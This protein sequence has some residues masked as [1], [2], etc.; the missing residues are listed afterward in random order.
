VFTNGVDPVCKWDPTV[1]STVSIDEMDT[2]FTTP[3]TNAIDTALMVI[4]F[5]GR[6]VY[7]NT[8]ESATRFPR[9]A[10]FTAAGSFQS[11][12][13]DLDF[14]DAPAEMGDMVTGQF[15]GERFF[16][17]FET[18]WMEL[19]S[20]NDSNQP[21]VWRPF[22]SRFGAVSKLSTIQDNERLIS[23]SKTSMQALDPNGQ[24]YFDEEVPDLV[25]NYSTSNTD[26]CAAIRNES[27]RALWWTYVDVAD[28]RPNNILAATYNEKGE[29]AWS[30]YD[31]RFNVFSEFDSDQSPSWNSLG[32][33]PMNSYVGVSFNDARVGA[34][35]FTQIIGGSDKGLIHRFDGVSNT[36]FR[37]D[38]PGTIEF[39]IETQRL[40]PYPGQ[41]SH[42]AW[43]DIYCDAS[44][45]AELMI[46]FYADT[47]SAAYLTKTISLTP[48]STGTKVYRRVSVGQIASF[49]RMKLF[50]S[51]GKFFA[52]DALIPWFRPAG[53]LRVFN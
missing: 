37:A 8:T 10:R 31:Q 27:E 42:F 49:H 29:V 47:T 11:W 34:E 38:G 4:R 26:Q 39:E 45:D 9:R 21:L 43:L 6:L 5:G 19:V 46:H 2:D 24:Y 25:L 50:S 44:R 35:G 12:D 20:T 7:L 14:T 15:I 13:S 52:I 1:S 3:G 41:R 22:I 18:G 16:A 33:N 36:D 48:D 23:R 17:G 53:R 40:S 28:T 51:D 30:Q 32:P